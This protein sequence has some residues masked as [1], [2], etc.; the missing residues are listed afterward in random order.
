MKGEIESDC[1]FKDEFI[2]NNVTREKKTLILQNCLMRK[3]SAK[4]NKKIFDFE[5]EE[6]LDQYCSI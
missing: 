5:W 2:S 1:H 4:Q 6:N 3:R